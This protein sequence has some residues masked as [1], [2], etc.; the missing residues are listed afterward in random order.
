MA[1]TLSSSAFSANQPIPK[2]FT[3][4]GEDKTPAL[5]WEGAPE[6]TKGFALIMDDPDAPPGTW[7]HWVV[8]DIPATE[9]QLPE[10]LPKGDSLPNGAKQGLVWGV[11]DFSKVGYHGP[12]PPPGNPHR[13]Y[14][15]LYALDQ[16]LKL[17]PRATKFDLEKAMKGHV[18]GE[19]SLMGTYGR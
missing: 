16:E 14:F 17:P 9:S 7:V 8:Y 19:T 2:P 18:L 5:S 15:K 4:D 13:Y 12:C 6:G 10:G 1:L 11:N 3:C